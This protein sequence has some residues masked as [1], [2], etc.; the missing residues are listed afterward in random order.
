MEFIAGAI[1]GFCSVTSIYPSEYMRIKLQ[2][3]INANYKQIIIS[4]YKNYGITGFYRGWISSVARN[5]VDISLRFGLYKN[6]N[7]YTDNRVISGVLTGIATPLLTLPLINITNRGVVTQLAN[8]SV[9]YSLKDD[10]LYMR[11]NPVFLYKG[12]QLTIAKSILS[13]LGLFTA[14]DYLKDHYSTAYAAPIAG[15]LNCSLNNPMD[16]IITKK[17]TNY[18][19]DM[20][21]KD[22]VR[23]IYRER[24]ILG[25]YRGF[26]I[27]SVRPIIGRTVMFYSYE[28]CI[29]HL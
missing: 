18:N 21:Y 3:D 7:S 22:I 26:L 16:V 28:F 25:F 23:S 1:A 8:D 27:R 6:I 20:T 11:R 9:R 12:L 10:I 14:Y 17:Q 29:R 15:V 4:T 5:S 2:H 24:G 13:A 19:N